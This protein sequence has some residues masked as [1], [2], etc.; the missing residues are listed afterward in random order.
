MSDDRP[1]KGYWGRSAA[2]YDQA[3]FRGVYGRLTG[4]RELRLMERGFRRLGGAG[5]SLSILDVPAGTGRLAVRLLEH[6]HAVTVADISPN[7]LEIAERTHQLSRHVTFDGSVVCD[8][9]DLPFEKD[10]FDV[11]ACLRFMG[12]LTPES[13]ERVLVEA[14][15]VARLGSVVTFERDTLLTRLRV[16][17]LRTIRRRE[18]YTDW[19]PV[20]PRDLEALL[21]AHG[22]SRRWSRGL[23]P[24]ISL[25]V[26]YSIQAEALAESGPSA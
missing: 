26:V 24:L 5:R 25:T 1:R 14:M 13:R 10:S 16:W 17:T 19:Y 2:T 20:R 7:M 9:E 21:A 12:H 18:S 22:W 15:R 11:V 6:G 3:R 4:A 23:L 8:A